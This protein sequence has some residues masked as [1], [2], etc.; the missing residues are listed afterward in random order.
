MCKNSDDDTGLNKS[1]F[2]L[3]PMSERLNKYHS[4]LYGFEERTYYLW[5]DA[6]SLYE[7]FTI[8]S[9]EVN[10][11]YKNRYCQIAAD[12]KDLVFSV[13]FRLHA[14][15]CVVAKEVLALMRSGYPDGANARCR[16]LNEFVIICLFIAKHGNEVAKRFDDHRTIET[17]K[18]ASEFQKYCKQRG[19]LPFSTEEI[20]SLKK[21]QDELI[22][23]Y[24]KSFKGN[25]GWAAGVLKNP[26]PNLTDLMKD[27]ELSYLSPSYR[28][29]SWS[30][31]ASN[32]KCM[33]FT[34]ASP[35]EEDIILTG[36]S[37]IGMADPGCSAAMSLWHMNRILITL[38]ENQ[39][40]QLI[41]D[42]MTVLVDK[43]CKA[44]IDIHNSIDTKYVRMT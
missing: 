33:M 37:N 6:F 18:A 2:D 10:S 11:V 16:T 20:E 5:Y 1:I 12:E 24:Q 32:A 23:L 14:K 8:Q 38:R 39:N 34:L 40:N 27:V 9:Q 26:K 17:Y 19:E 31:H 41:L 15:S 35:P 29:A 25:Y 28:M 30:I 13:I 22:A 36:E 4:E 3:L 42:S 44:F 43:M 21:K 7:Y